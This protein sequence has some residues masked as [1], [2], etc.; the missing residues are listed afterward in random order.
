MTKQQTCL[1]F[2]IT[3]I[4]GSLVGTI[5][6][7]VIGVKI[8]DQP[9]PVEEEK[10]IINSELVVERIKEQSFLITRTVISDQEVQIK[11]DQGSSWSNWWWG[12]EVTA[13][14][15]M[16]VDVGVDIS[17]ITEEQIEVD[18]ENK[19]IYINFPEAEIYETSLKGTIEVS[20]KKGLLKRILDSDTDEDYNLALDH[21]KMAAEDG[22]SQDQELMQE[23]QNSALS[24]LQVLLSDTEYTVQIM[25]E[26]TESEE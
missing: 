26:N 19:I 21:L 5:L 15:L 14:G 16:Q 3:F 12:Y 22:V 20:A 24:T 9:A 10:I 11:V 6:G 7:V 25:E 4:I 2:L 1:S 13:K 8:A 23:A 18:D 17:K